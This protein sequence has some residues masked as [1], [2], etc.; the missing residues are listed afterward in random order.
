MKNAYF[1]GHKGSVGVIFQGIVSDVGA[2]IARYSLFQL[3]QYVIGC[4]IWISV[5][6]ASVGSDILNQKIT[7]LYWI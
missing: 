3:V 6:Y 5:L 1:K 2:L 7:T 4:L